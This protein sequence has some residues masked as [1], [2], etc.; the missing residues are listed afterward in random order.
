M[1][2]V[3]DSGADVDAVGFPDEGPRH[4][5]GP[6]YGPRYCIFVDVTAAAYAV[7]SGRLM[8]RRRPARNDAVQVSPRPVR[9]A[10][11]Q[12]VNAVERTAVDRAATGE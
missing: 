9:P 8:P 12:P 7:A 2:D 10:S 1:A 11:V 5:W 6:R 4:D 3:V